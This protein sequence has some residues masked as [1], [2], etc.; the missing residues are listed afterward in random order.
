MRR[1]FGVDRSS[2]D[3]RDSGGLVESD[4]TVTRVVRA[5]G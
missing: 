5:M 4:S 2:C 1:E 3:G